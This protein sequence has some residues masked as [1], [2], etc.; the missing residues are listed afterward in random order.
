MEEKLIDLE[1]VPSCFL[2]A[3]QVS[4]MQASDANYTTA[5]RPYITC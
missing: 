5:L 4:E 3:N 2:I 1:V